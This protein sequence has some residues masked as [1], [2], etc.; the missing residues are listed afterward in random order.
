M[1]CLNNLRTNNL[2]LH[3]KIALCFC[4]KKTKAADRGVGESAS[5]LQREVWSKHRIVGVEPVQGARR[6]SERYSSSRVG[7]GEKG[8]TVAALAGRAMRRNESG[9]SARTILLTDS[10]QL[11]Y[12]VQPSGE[13]AT[14]TD[15]FFDGDQRDRV[16]R[17]PKGFFDD[18]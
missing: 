13:N 12:Y 6:P 5:G 1:Y 11:D 16:G 2:R 17:L 15:P 10:D 3:F 14:R 4:R 9:D 8:M 18:V 7:I